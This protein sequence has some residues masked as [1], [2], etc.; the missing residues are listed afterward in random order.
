MKPPAGRVNR[1]NRPP[2]NVTSR[3][4]PAHYVSEQPCVRRRTSRR[5]TNTNG[6]QRAVTLTTLLKL[7]HRSVDAVQRSSSLLSSSCPFVLSA[8]QPDVWTACTRSGVFSC[9]CECEDTKGAPSVFS[10]SGLNVSS[11]CFG[12]QVRAQTGRTLDL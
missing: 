11:R 1:Q 8:L 9:L 10:G 4:A 12:A 5:T 2:E 3:F 7:L 6:D